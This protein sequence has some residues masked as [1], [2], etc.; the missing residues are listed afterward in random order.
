MNKTNLINMKPL[1][2]LLKLTLLSLTGSAQ[3]IDTLHFK[4]NK[5]VSSDETFDYYRVITKVDGLTYRVKEFGCQNNLKS[6][7]TYKT[8]S[9]IDVNSKNL[10][11]LIEKEKLVLHG[12]L[13]RYSK[14]G[15]IF[16]ETKYDFGKSVYGPVEYYKGDTIWIKPDVFP[17]FQ[18]KGPD[19]LRSYIR[20][21]IKYP[22]SAWKKRLQG[23]VY[24]TFV[25]NKVGEVVGSEVT[26]GVDP[27]IDAEALR[28]VN[29]TSRQWVPGKYEGK[30]ISIKYTI[31]INFILQ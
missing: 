9:S 25:V 11:K 4:N 31:P 5:I 23:K 29:S 2:L 3:I 8:K 22:I 24:V 26:R 1:I 14:I 17:V 7:F 28:V 10:T 6:T 16:S 12:S 27:D 19:A 15:E 30:P 20:D 21:E 13:L 18:G